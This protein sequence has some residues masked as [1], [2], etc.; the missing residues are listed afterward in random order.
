MG[1]PNK[2][3]DTRTAAEGWP[4]IRFRWS[5]RFSPHVIVFL[6]AVP[7]R[8][9]LPA[10]LGYLAWLFAT[11]IVGFG[12]MVWVANRW[13]GTYG[14]LPMRWRAGTTFRV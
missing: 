14:N 9:G 10:F 13:S 6:A 5:M 4:A 7:E 3:R 12:L 1:D 2:A 11:L 8:P